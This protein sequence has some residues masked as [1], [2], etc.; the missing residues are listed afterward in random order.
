LPVATSTTWAEPS[1]LP[2]S[3]NDRATY[4]P[5]S[6]ATY[7]SIAVVRPSFISFGSTSTRSDFRSSGD[8][9][10]TSISWF[11]GGW[12]FNA[13]SRPPRCWNAR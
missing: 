9:S 13:K 2:F 12:R 7:Q 6:E 10:T 8:F 4:L 5:F 3:D 11:F 1:S